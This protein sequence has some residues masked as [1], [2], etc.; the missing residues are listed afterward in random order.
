[1]ARKDEHVYQLYI[2]RDLWDR[3]QRKAESAKPAPLSMKTV[4]IQLLDGWAPETSDHVAQPE[5]TKSV[6][7]RGISNPKKEPFNPLASQSKVAQARTAAVK[8]GTEPPHI[9]PSTVN[10]PDLGSAF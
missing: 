3:A 6:I 5:M 2:P 1:M 10:E 4:I 8:L 9:S 7:S